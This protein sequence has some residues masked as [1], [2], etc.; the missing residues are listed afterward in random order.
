MAFGHWI[1]CRRWLPIGA[2][3]AACLALLVEETGAWGERTLLGR[4]VTKVAQIKIQSAQ[5]EKLKEKLDKMMEESHVLTEQVRQ[6]REFRQQS[7]VE[8][9]QKVAELQKRYE[10][11]LEQMRRDFDEQVLAV[12]EEMWAQAQRDREVFE[13]DLNVRQESEKAAIEADAQ[14]RTKVLVD[15]V[16]SKMAAEAERDRELY[17]KRAAL[18]E[19]GQELAREDRKMLQAEKDELVRQLEETIAAEDAK[20]KKIIVKFKTR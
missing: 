20:R 18:A 6:H 3:A 16:K 5:L 14:A 1:W 10:L 12:R 11:E 4:R 15:E 13:A 8:L 2:I 7:S 19:E 17:A 9:R